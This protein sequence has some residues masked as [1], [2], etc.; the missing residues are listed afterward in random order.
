MKTLQITLAGVA[1]AL[2]AVACGKAAP[3]EPAGELAVPS[4]VK[5]HGT[6]A[7]T[8]LTFQWSAVEGA[9][10]YNWKLSTEGEQD[11]T[12]DVAN[13]NVTVSG[14]IPGTDY[15]FSVRSVAGTQ[16]SA[17]S[18]PVVAKTAGKK[19]T[20]GVNCVDAPLVIEVGTSA[21]LG[22]SGKILV[23]KDGVKDAVD[24][25]DL[26][27]IAKAQK[28]EDGT[29]VPA[30][31]M[32]TVTASHTFMD[33]LHSGSVK[34]VVHYTPLRLKE[35]KLY[36]KLH[37]QVLDFSSSYY[38]TMDESVAGKAIGKGEFTFTTKAAPTGTTL[39]VNPDGSEDFC[40]VQGALTYAASLGKDTA[41]TIEVGEGTYPELLFLQGKNNVTI[42]GVSREKSVI[43]YPNSENYLSGS[44]N[45]CLFLAKS[46]SGLTLENLTV[47]NTYYTSDHKG[48]AEAIYFN[49][50]D[51]GRLVIEDCALISWQDTFLCKG[52]VYVHKSLIAGHCDYIW[53]YPKACLFEDCEIRS[54]AAGYI[55]Q[56]RVQNAANKGF[57]FLNCRLTAESGVADGKM[58]LARS[59]GQADCYDNVTYVN[60]TMS[61]VIAPAGWFTSPAPNPSTPTATA[62]WKE[63]GTTGVSTTSRNAYGKI[64]TATEAEPYSSRQ[65]VLGW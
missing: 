47:E 3:A 52:E 27:D 18:T 36:V 59:G 25:I 50:A 53:G 6:A 46:C 41:V 29:F 19:P 13:R 15:S 48:Q 63:Y 49:A 62:G 28:L 10:G 55:V 34:R 14:L 16:T 22:T 43:A 30:S 2:M 24:V 32:T 35:G 56:A 20:P 9:S 17:W 26:A 40:T 33:E 64:L 58:Y 57:V 11:L 31:Q 5:L 65:A 7:E 23:Y 12:G 54:R 44:D 8:S 21:S 4:G 61:P 37:N 42:K 38:L 51:N 45:R 39:T 1:A 60:C